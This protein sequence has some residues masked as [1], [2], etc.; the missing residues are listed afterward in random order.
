MPMDHYENV[1]LSPSVLTIKFIISNLFFIIERIV[2]HYHFFRLHIDT[3][4][5]LCIGID[6]DTEK[7]KVQPTS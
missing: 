5:K 2:A 4:L 3:A 7:Y 6:I 1:A